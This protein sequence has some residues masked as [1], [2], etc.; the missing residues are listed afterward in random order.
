MWEWACGYAKKKV[1]VL[2]SV[3][4]YKDDPSRDR[5]YRAFSSK[6]GS[7]HHIR[8]LY[9][10]KRKYFRYALW[11]PMKTNQMR[12]A[13]AIHSK[14]ATARKSDIVTCLLAE[15]QRQTEEWKSFP[16]K[17]KREGFRYALIGK[18]LAWRSRRQAKNE[19]LGILGDWFG[20]KI[21]FSLVG[22]ELEEES[23]GKK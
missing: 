14:L 15:T 3:E 7:Q 12:K 18:L 13:K 22:P 10:E 11:K 4:I 21:W 6:G 20:E 9:R 5:D 17:K 19:K 16:V 2:W 23:G 8:N 1:L